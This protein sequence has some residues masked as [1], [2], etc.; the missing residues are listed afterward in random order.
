MVFTPLLIAA[1]L[2]IAAR[3]ANDWAQPCFGECNWD[4]TSD[5]GSGTV[6]IAGPSAAVSDITPAAGWMIMDCDPNTAD[7][8]I[9]LVCQDPSKGC[10]HIYTDSAAG[11]LVRLPKSCGSTPFALVTRDWVH[12]DQSI[13]A[14]KRSSIVRRDGSDPVVKGMSLATNFADVDTPTN[15]NVTLF[16]MG[17]SVP[18]A[19]GNFTV[20][21]PSGTAASKRGLGSWIDSSL[22]GLSQVHA[23]LIGNFNKNI[24]GSSP[25]NFDKD[26]PIFDQKI[27]CP[28]NGAVPAFSGEAKVDL[29]AKVDGTVNYGIA[30]SG[31][32]I[33]P[34]IS[35]FGLFVG[36][37]TSITGT[38]GL[39][40]TLTGSISSGKISV[41]EVGLPGLDF[42]KIFS[43]GPTFSVNVEAT[44][45]LDANVDMDVDLAYDV[46]GME[47][48]FPPGSNS[49]A[50]T[51]TPGDSNLKLSVSPNVTSHG[52][53]AAHLIPSLAFGISALGGITKAT[54]NLDLDADAALD[55]S[56]TA[57]ALASASTSGNNAS[58]GVGGC[59]D[60]T[61]GLAVNAG[62]D[63]DFFSIF[64]KG[65]QVP[66]F[67][68][69]FDLFKGI[70]RQ[71]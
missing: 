8:D 3:A 35:E 62:A 25:I 65:L 2:P 68:K 27:D 67:T 48:F 43:I 1:L 52:Q 17:S 9:R 12:K 23:E 44:A 60:I 24:T 50:G 11:T 41:F 57:A 69:T 64:K 70:H 22:K 5:T 14:S 10:D 34:K 61:S 66:L 32:I 20:D 19:A 13:P 59:V 21:P 42:P 46:K 55:L 54:I 31:S 40:A 45:S 7:Q 53:V 30:A 37:D 28:Q 51:F 6:R 47:L 18:G 36:L 63:A 71:V 38:L 26:F 33:P 56:L 15:G 4:I 39:G 49:Q 16:L 29:D 58:T